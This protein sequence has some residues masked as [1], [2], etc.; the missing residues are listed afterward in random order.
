MR[1][2][3]TA[4]NAVAMLPRK[5]FEQAQETG[6]SNIVSSGID[7]EDQGGKHPEHTQFLPLST[8][9]RT[10]GRT[11]AAKQRA[12]GFSPSLFSGWSAPCARLNT[13]PKNATILQSAAPQRTAPQRQAS[14]VTQASGSEEKHRPHNRCRTP[15]QA[16]PKCSHGGEG[17][18]ETRQGL[19]RA[20]RT[21]RRG[22]AVSAVRPGCVVRLLLGRH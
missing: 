20:L 4:T 11:T 8:T 3:S 18:D 1:A 14:L 15:R 2:S 5:T 12:L 17:A 7:G 21:R 16:R 13:M 9:D 22:P 6:G 19:R 10:L